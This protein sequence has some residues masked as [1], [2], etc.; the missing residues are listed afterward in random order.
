MTDLSL[1][2]ARRAAAACA[3]VE[4]GWVTLMG[5]FRGIPQYSKE[6]PTILV[7]FYIDMCIY[8]YI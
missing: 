4:P 2:T 1:A 8:L 6:H 3:A 7:H 5:G